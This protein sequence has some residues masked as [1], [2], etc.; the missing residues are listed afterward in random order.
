MKNAIVIHPSDNVAVAI[1][2]IAA[3]SAAEYRITGGGEGSVTALEDITIYHKVAIRAIKAG[4]KIIKYGEHIGEAG[5]DIPAGGYVHT[6]NVVSV[7]ENL[8]ER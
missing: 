2:P 7:R 8:D 5:C 6:H 3:G 4:E 1:E